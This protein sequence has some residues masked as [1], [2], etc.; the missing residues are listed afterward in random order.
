MV[1]VIYPL[2]PLSFVTKPQILSPSFQLICLNIAGASYVVV[3]QLALSLPCRAEKQWVETVGLPLRSVSLK[4]LL[5]WSSHLLHGVMG[6]AKPDGS[7]LFTELR[8]ALSNAIYLTVLCQELNKGRVFSSLPSAVHT[9][10]M[11]C[12]QERNRRLQLSC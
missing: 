12:K 9:S 2:S 1:L 3:V 5:P 4:V 6:S 7:S 11:R 10:P 8:V